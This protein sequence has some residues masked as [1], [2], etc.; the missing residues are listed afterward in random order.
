MPLAKALRVT[1]ETLKLHDLR[2][3]IK[4]LA[5]GKL[6]TAFDILL[7]I[8][9]GADG[10]LPEPNPVEPNREEFWW[11]LTKGNYLCELLLQIKRDGHQISHIRLCGSSALDRS[12]PGR[13]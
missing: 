6:I 4:V 2:Q 9:A 10:I 12:R 13:C 11:S 1:D 8:E 5:S 3:R 7:A